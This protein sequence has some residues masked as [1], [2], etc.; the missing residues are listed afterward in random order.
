MVPS[1]PLVFI[2]IL[3]LNSTLGHCLNFGVQYRE[4]LYIL[5]KLEDENKILSTLESTNDTQARKKYLY[6][7]LANFARAAVDSLCVVK[8]LDLFTQD[9]R[10]E[11]LSGRVSLKLYTGPPT[12]RGTITDKEIA[13]V[14]TRPWQPGMLGNLNVHRYSPNSKFQ[15]ISIKEEIIHEIENFMKPHQIE[16]TEAINLIEEAAIEAIYSATNMR[17]GI[18][19]VDKLNLEELIR[20]IS[21]VRRGRDEKISSDLLAVREAARNR[22]EEIFYC[23]DEKIEDFQKIAKNPSTA[24]TKRVSYVDIDQSSRKDRIDFAILA[25][26]PDERIAICNTLG[27]TDDHRSDKGIHVYWMRN[28]PLIN[29]KSYRCI[30]AE[31]TDMGNPESVLLT[32]A[33]IDDWS[34][35]AIILVGIAASVSKEVYLGDIVIASDIYYYERGK[36]LPTGKKPEPK[37]IPADA[38][39]FNKAKPLSDWDAVVSYP[40]P[41]R[42]N[43]KPRVHFGIIASGEKVVADEIKRDEIVSGQR[44]IIAI[45][46]ESYGVNLA[47]WQEINKIHTLVIKG[48]SDKADVKKN[49]KW[50][51]Y[52][53]YAAAGFLKYYLEH[54]PLDP[55]V[56]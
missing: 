20:S 47:S 42:S 21:Y 12:F 19:H 4:E 30:V 17:I 23:L 40:R 8:A 11:D 51:Q 32:K 2:H 45:E 33:V 39:L 1:D 6:D 25:A 18:G 55:G 37:M 24:S 36:E 56:S 46:M 49:D 41:G 22:F 29:G 53:A 48:I 34:P 31:M 54:E 52:A 16:L 44:K 7:P 28:L 14:T 38:L 43:K 27:L 5:Q 13:Y 9:S 35:R 15:W 50:R 26:L 3:S 10:Y